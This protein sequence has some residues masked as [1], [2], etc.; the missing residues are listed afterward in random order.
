MTAE[1]LMAGIKLAVHDSATADVIASVQAPAGRK[2]A[3][4]LLQLS[5]W[6]NALSESDKTN[7][8]AMVLHGVHA[9]LFGVFAVIDGVRAIED[10][11][12]KSQ[13]NGTRRK[14]VSARV[15][16][17]LRRNSHEGCS[18]ALLSDCFLDHGHQGSH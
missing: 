11:D 12:E 7:V 8:R 15:T 9:A 18:T 16:G 3:P 6:Y 5:G 1:E 13:F 4:A 14:S 10:T 17:S 2:P